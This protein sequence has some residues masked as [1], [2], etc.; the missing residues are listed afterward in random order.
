MPE[1]IIYKMVDGKKVKMSAEEISARK[2]EEQ[3]WAEEQSKVPVELQLDSY[4]IEKL[5]LLNSAGA[6]PDGLT[7]LVMTLSS[8]INDTFKR[9]QGKLSPGLFKTAIKDVINQ[10]AP[11]LV[12]DALKEVHA[13]LLAV[14]DKALP[15]E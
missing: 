5:E 2:A 15:S 3:A 7:G 11:L 4:F 12:S 14:V 8:T 13:E 10:A 9:Y 1:D 6:L